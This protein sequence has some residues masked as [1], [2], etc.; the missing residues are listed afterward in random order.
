MRKQLVRKA[1][2]QA[3]AP[4]TETQLSTGEVTNVSKQDELGTKCSLTACRVADIKETPL[5]RFWDLQYP[6]WVVNADLFVEHDSAAFV[7]N[8]LLDVMMLGMHLIFYG[9]TDMVYRI[10][11]DMQRL[12]CIKK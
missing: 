9:E 8:W 10:G 11:R 1:E 2:G 7:L 5:A 12:C 3:S 6:L 4:P